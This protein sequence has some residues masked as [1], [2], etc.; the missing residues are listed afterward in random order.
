MTAKETDTEPLAVKPPS[1]LQSSVVTPTEDEQL[2]TD[3]QTPVASPGELEGVAA[4]GP[5]KQAP[6]E[7]QVQDSQPKSQPE[8][9]PQPQADTAPQPPDQEVAL[10]SG[11]A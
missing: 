5:A 3:A 10:V 4:A 11:A 9:A 6:S 2:A 8:E 7:A 1:D